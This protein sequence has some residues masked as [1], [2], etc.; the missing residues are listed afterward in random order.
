[1]LF[2]LVNLMAEKKTLFERPCRRLVLVYLI[3][4]I[5]GRFV[6]VVVILFFICMESEARY[7]LRMRSIAIIQR[8]QI[9]QEIVAIFSDQTFTAAMLLY[10]HTLLCATVLLAGRSNSKCSSFSI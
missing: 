5:V 9:L 7:G 4:S 8:W 10:V 1:M 2:G 6:V 3:L